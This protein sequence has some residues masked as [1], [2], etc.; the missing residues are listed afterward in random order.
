MVSDDIERSCHQ[1]WNKYVCVRTAS[2]CRSNS[3]TGN[4]TAAS[5]S[6]C[7]GSCGSS[8]SAAAA[9]A[10]WRDP[11]SAAN[12]YTKRRDS[13]DSGTCCV[14]V[15]RGQQLFSDVLSHKYRNGDTVSPLGMDRLYTKDP[16]VGQN[17]FTTYSRTPLIWLIRMVSHPDMQ[18]IVE[19]SLQVG[20]I[21]C[22]NFGC[23]YSQYI[24]LF[25]LLDHV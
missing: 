11:D 9:A 23:C 7:S 10:E 12:S 24:A 18:K 16:F 5:K 6:G 19:F 13:A 22:L 15:I 21:G 20:N 25:K 3:V 1:Q 4:T 2:S 17:R 14:S 8:R